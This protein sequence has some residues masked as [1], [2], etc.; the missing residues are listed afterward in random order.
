VP[1][2][3]A[4]HQWGRAASRWEFDLIRIFGHYVSTR[5]LVLLLL[6][7]SAFFCVLLFAGRTRL[8]DAATLPSLFP[9]AL[10]FALVTCIAFSASG[11]Y[12]SGLSQSLRRVVPAIVVSLLIAMLGLGIISYLFPRAYI[13]RGVLTLAISLAFV[14]TFFTRVVLGRFAL[15]GVLR[16]RVM[17]VGGGEDV[18]HVIATVD[19][20]AKLHSE[21][22]AIAPLSQH[23]TV[24][25]NIAPVLDGANLPL[26]CA[27][28]RIDEIVVALRDQRGST[29]PMDALLQCKLK[30]VQVTDLSAFLERIQGRIRLDG[31]RA[32]TLIYGDG[33]RQG[34]T[35]T[36]SKR[37]FD[38]ITSL[39]L[40][41]LAAPIMVIAAIIVA[42]ESKGP[43]LY[44]QERV[45]EGSKTFG[46][47]KFR[48]MI[49]DA[50][51]DGKPR[52]AQTNDSRITRFG[53]FMRRTRIDELPQLLNVLRGEMSF[54]GPRP[55]RPFFVSQ[56]KQRIPLYDARHTVKPGLTGW[57]QVRHSYA[58][59]EED[60]RAKLEYDLFYVKN[61]TLLL[62]ILV[63]IETAG[64]VVTGKGAR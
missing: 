49:A 54:V 12:Q 34:A 1:N 48:S 27:N 36:I 50:E 5:V 62:D 55:E 14:V 21:I 38:V 11:L 19:D 30:G 28:L 60:S 17:I 40:L 41:V 53:K 16:S 20:R 13:G 22:V 6:E 31:L 43:V 29:L 44:T 57:A 18:N 23:T 64:V 39:T 2:N 47:L 33:F 63:L 52:W 59:S 9:D 61:H 51:K 24:P 46:I 26:A 3:K 37:I 15:S 45:G 56:L 8:G 10:L 35:R 7:A 4:A 25:S 58:A 32:S 42:L